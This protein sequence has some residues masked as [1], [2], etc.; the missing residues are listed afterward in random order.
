[1]QGLFHTIRSNQYNLSL[2]ISIRRAE[3]QSASCKCCRFKG[4]AT[5]GVGVALY[6]GNTK[7][8][9][10]V[11]SPSDC[12]YLHDTLAN[13][14]DWSL[15]N[16]IVFNASKCKTL[17]VTRKKSPLLHQYSMAFNLSEVWMRKT[18]VLPLP[19]HFPGSFI[20]S[21]S[22]LKQTSSLVFSNGHALY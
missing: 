2:L 7:L 20:S 11:V 22:Q 1:M 9:K 21:P 10:S 13:I 4:E 3:S 16:N 19:A 6:A 14:H 5:G 8:Y 12:L 15:R 17:S 18:L